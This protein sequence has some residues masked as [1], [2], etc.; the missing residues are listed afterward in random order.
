MTFLAINLI[1]Q[2][3][4]ASHI[5]ALTIHPDIS[6]IINGGGIET[7]AVPPTGATIYRLR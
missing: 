7:L 4:V 3:R 2:E 1:Q 5:L 6:F